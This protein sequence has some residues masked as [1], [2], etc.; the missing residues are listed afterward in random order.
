LSF[1]GVITVYEKAW[2][3]APVPPAEGWSDE[4]ALAAARARC[5]RL[6]SAAVSKM[7]TAPFE[8]AFS[9][10]F[11]SLLLLLVFTC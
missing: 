9:T 11:F 2:V 8:D 6:Q 1:P 3:K 7:N 10:S 5:V 4:D